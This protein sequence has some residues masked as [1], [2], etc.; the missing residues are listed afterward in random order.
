M[1]ALARLTTYLERTTGQGG[2][3]SVDRRFV[4]QGRVLVVE[5]RGHGQLDGI[6]RC[7]MVIARTSFQVVILPGESVVEAVATCSDDDKINKDQHGSTTTRLHD[8]ARKAGATLT[9]GQTAFRVFLFAAANHPH[10]LLESS[11]NGT[12]VS[13]FS[14]YRV[15]RVT[16]IYQLYDITTTTATSSPYHPAIV[17]LLPPLVDKLGGR[18]SA[19]VPH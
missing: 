7:S 14:K 2:G 13:A 11:L 19:L 18:S 8:N 5:H 12:L 15:T 6:A 17:K 10:N 3:A 4:A 9:F 16:S 1:T